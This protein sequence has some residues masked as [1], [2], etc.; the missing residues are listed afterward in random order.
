M[1]LVDRE[2][3]DTGARELG[4]E[5]FVVEPLRRDV[6]QLQRVCP[7]TLEDLA[8]LA[9]IEARIE[10]RG[11][12][13]V[14]LQEIDLVLHQRDQRRDD[15]GRPLEQQR[16]QLVAQ[17]LA[18]P[19]RKDGKRRA[20]REERLD[21]LLLPRPKRLEAECLSK[22]FERTRGRR[23]ALRHRGQGSPHP[24]LI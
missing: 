4:E 13:P 23:C 8:L 17:A 18:G 11:G 1:S 21:D 12:D 14:A 6:E 16:R 9:R 2:E 15:D 5:P 10:A 24:V 20:S 3:R 7:E 19:G 22:R